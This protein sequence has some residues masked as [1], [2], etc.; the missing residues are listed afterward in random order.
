MKEA[1]KKKR[2]MKM[3]KKKCFIRF[4]SS[5]RPN[6]NNIQSQRYFCLLAF[7]LVENVCVEN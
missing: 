7:L 3:M 6:K 1:K 4:V 2:R 5:E